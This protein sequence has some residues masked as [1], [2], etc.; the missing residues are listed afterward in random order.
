MKKLY[1][2][3][4]S[5]YTTETTRGKHDDSTPEDCAFCT[6]FNMEDDAKHF[7]LARSKHHAILLNLYPYNAGH[8]LIVPYAH[9]KNMDDLSHEARIELIELLTQ[10]ITILKNTLNAEGINVGLNLGKASG[11]GIPSHIHWHT[12]PRWHGDTNF[13]P[14]LA[15]TK[16]VSYDL[17]VMY[18][19]L[20]EPFQKLL[21]NE[22]K[23]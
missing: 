9:V 21:L 12:L 23:L 17:E 15:D 20:I 19:K 3:W 2:P 7:I 5:S 22:V 11:A 8:L 16:A 14:L 13:L 1:A 4:R 10:S 18:K 6:K